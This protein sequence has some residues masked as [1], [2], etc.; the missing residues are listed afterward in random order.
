MLGRATLRRGT[1]RWDP[2]GGQ[3]GRSRRALTL[4]QASDVW[5]R[6]FVG[7][8]ASTLVEVPRLVHPDMLVEIEAVAVPR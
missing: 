5:H 7:R 4:G 3:G 8:P 1:V 2:R 6:H